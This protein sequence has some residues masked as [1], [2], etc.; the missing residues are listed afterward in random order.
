MEEDRPQRE[1]KSIPPRVMP[2]SPQRGHCGHSCYYPH[3]S[4][5]SL[6]L[7]GLAL[8]AGVSWSK[9]TVRDVMA[10]KDLGVYS[11]SF[12][13]PVDPTGVRLVRLTPAN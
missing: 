4:V 9:A 5:I 12:T 11:D 13:A 3:Y 10:G 7:A 6:P 1:F 8:Q 2:L